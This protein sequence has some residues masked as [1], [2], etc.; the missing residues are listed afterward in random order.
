MSDQDTRQEGHEDHHGDHDHKEFTIYVNTRAQQVE[1]PDVTYE[2]IVRLA[3]PSDHGGNNPGYTVTYQ[4][5][6]GSKDGQLVPGQSVRVR[7][8][9]IFDVT[10]TVLS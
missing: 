10:P 7:E 4:R 9:M 1:G 2:E 5:G 3:Y 8:H 6:H